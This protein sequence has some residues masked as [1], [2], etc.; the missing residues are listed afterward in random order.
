DRSENK[1]HPRCGCPL[2]KSKEKSP[3]EFQ[4]F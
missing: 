4:E 2:H 3:P 1:E